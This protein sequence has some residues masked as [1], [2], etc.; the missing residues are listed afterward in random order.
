MI[1]HSNNSQV[2]T[3]VSK[4]QTKQ[5]PLLSSPD[6]LMSTVNEHTGGYRLPPPPRDR[7]QR[8]PAHISSSSQTFEDANH[9]NLSVSNQ[10][11]T[12]YCLSYC[13]MQQ[14]TRYCRILWMLHEGADVTYLKTVPAISCGY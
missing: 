12:H 3:T 10:R 13:G 11:D 5:L 8:T 9:N 2:D 4:L 7:T 14:E 1:L 6:L